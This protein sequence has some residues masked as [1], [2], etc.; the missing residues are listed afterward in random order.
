M[1]QQTS[2]S[3]PASLIPHFTMASRNSHAIIEDEVY[4][5][6]QEMWTLEEQLEILALCGNYHLISFVANTARV[7]NEVTGARFPG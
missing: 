5:K 3:T 4:G 6:F 2:S 7:E 1:R